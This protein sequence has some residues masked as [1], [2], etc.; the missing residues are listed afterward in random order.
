MHP[1]Q[2]TMS[3]YEPTNAVNIKLLN[4]TRYYRSQE[5]HPVRALFNGNKNDMVYLDD[6]S[7]VKSKFKPT[8]YG[9][10]KPMFSEL[11][12]KVKTS[13]EEKPHVGSRLDSLPFKLLTDR[14]LNHKVKY[15]NQLMHELE[16]LNSKINPLKINLEQ[17][18]SNYPCLIIQLNGA[19][20][21]HSEMLKTNEGAKEY[22]ESYNELLTQLMIASI[23]K[24]LS[25]QGF[26]ANFD[27][28]QS[29]GFLTPTATDVHGAIRI[30]LG[31]VPSP[32]WIE[33][34]QKGINECNNLI[35]TLWKGNHITH[36]EISTTT[37][38]YITGSPADSL[39][40]DNI[41][42]TVG[43]KMMLTTMLSVPDSKDIPAALSNLFNSQNFKNFGL[44]SQK[45]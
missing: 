43:H 44:V 32:Q 14:I 16:P 22:N 30:S 42:K 8:Y 11:G 26:D 2:I 27:R 41:L 20:S 36:G 9:L 25:K 10:T 33:A 18:I 37:Q 28:R 3:S 19:Y 39:L 5:S 24:E 15:V 7:L 40:E 45:N 6:K 23:N 1:K 12:V 4:S 17:S 21:H 38:E 34:C 13:A 29:F 31:L 35:D